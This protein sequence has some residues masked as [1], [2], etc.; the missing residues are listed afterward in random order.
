M[1]KLLGIL[2]FLLAIG[3]SAN[4]IRGGDA[5]RRLTNEVLFAK[6]DWQV[7]SIRRVFVCV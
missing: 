4:C 2:P 3:G 5:S 1:N 7:F 6:Y